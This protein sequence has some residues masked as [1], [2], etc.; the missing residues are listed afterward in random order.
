MR[1]GWLLVALLLLSTPA[2]SNE[3]SLRKLSEVVSLSDL[4]MAS[5]L[6]YF[7][8]HVR[9]PDERSLT[10]IYASFYTLE[11]C[12][13]HLGQP[14]AQAR[15]LAQIKMLLAK[16]EALPASQRGRYPEL[17]QQLL[18]EHQKLRR[19]AAGAYAELRDGSDNIEQMINEQSHDLSSLLVDYQIR[20]YPEIAP[21]QRI[22]SASEQEVLTTSIDQRFKTLLTEQPEQAEALG[23]VNTQY[24]FIRAQLLN[25]GGRWQAGVEFYLS[26]AVLDLQEL[27]VLWSTRS[28]Q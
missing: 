10:S 3:A 8:V 19:A 27:A 22:F 26:R 20:H 11:M 16:L 25:P 15:P 23:K 4:L 28:G 12:M 21:S 6:G 17:L 7:N 13:A 24:R 18:N 1:K 2:W 9:S 14:P 5:A